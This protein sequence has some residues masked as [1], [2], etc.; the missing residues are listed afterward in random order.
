MGVHKQASVVQV[1]DMTGWGVA[2]NS[3]MLHW[4]VC[5]FPPIPF[6]CNYP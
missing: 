2:D 6:V 4:G 1:E 3:G 5:C